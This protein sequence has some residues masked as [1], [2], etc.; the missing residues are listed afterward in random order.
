MAGKPEGV[1]GVVRHAAYQ[2]AVTEYIVDPAGIDLPLQV[3]VSGPSAWKIGD[4]VRIRLP[5]QSA[6]IK[7][8]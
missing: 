5:R 3:Q 7:R 4:A 1:P 2:G 8:A 6:I